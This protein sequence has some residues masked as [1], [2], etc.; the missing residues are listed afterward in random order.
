[1]STMNGRATRGISSITKFKFS[2]K[3]LLFAGR[4]RALD[5]MIFFEG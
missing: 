5:V 2:N 3:W 4:F 1:M